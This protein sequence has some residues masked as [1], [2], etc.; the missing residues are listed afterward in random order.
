MPNQSSENQTKRK[1]AKVRNG[2]LL[3]YLSINYGKQYYANG[4]VTMRNIAENDVITEWNI[5]IHYNIEYGAEK[6]EKS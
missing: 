1:R 6:W 5:R 2:F 4:N 3:F